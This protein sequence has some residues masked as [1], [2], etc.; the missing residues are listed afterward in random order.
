MRSPTQILTASAPSIPRRIASSLALGLSEVNSTISLVNSCG[1]LRVNRWLGATMH[2]SMGTTLP[3]PILTPTASG[4][5]SVILY[6]SLKYAYSQQLVNAKK[7]IQR[8]TYLNCYGLHD[9]F[10]LVL[11]PLK[12]C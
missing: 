11:V 1:S 4:Y 12:L 8:G 3:P 5:L 6:A 9:A 2:S 7:R 10:S